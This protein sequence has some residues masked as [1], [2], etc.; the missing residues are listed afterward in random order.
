[1]RG[2]FVVA[3]PEVSSTMRWTKK[4]VRAGAEYVN[5]ILPSHWDATK[6]A[7]FQSRFRPAPVKP[8]LENLRLAVW[9]LKA[10]QD[11]A[12]GEGVSWGFRAR[13][14]VR[15]GQSRG[16]LSAYPETTGYI[17]ET[18]LDYGH[19]YGDTDAVARALRMGDW[20]VRMQL[21][22]GG[23]QGGMYGAEPVSSS[24]FV[25]GQ[26][27]F[28]LLKLYDETQ[29][30]RFLEAAERSG[31][32]L[33]S[34]LDDTGRFVRGHSHFCAAGP[35]AYEARTGW[36]LALLGRTTGERHYSDAARKMAEYAISC[37]QANGWF[38]ENDLDDHSVPLTHTIGYVLEGLWGIGEVLRFPECQDSVLRSLE[39]I[40]RLVE[41]DGFL[42]G[43]WKSDW[44]PAVSYC[45]L[46]GSCQ[47]AIVYLRAYRTHG[48]PNFLATAERLLGFVTATQGTPDRRQPY[49]GGIQGSYPFGGD[50]GQ[51]CLLN[52]ATK[53]FVDALMELFAST[54]RDIG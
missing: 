19:R 24:T 54:G 3:E 12:G 8:A 30:R 16:W 43:R 31:G 13:T 48:R 36:A 33:L 11:A 44:Q 32:F 53:F 23:T 25:T 41:P 42:P 15:S 49:R 5:A 47:I 2:E 17:I 35:K 4:M 52:W 20:E 10:A 29:E 34:C 40:D 1:M 46:T 7:H 26:V 50:Y 27:L 51:F 9:W 6:L 21:P 38:G 22:D 14:V 39:Q 28:G 45:C 18:M 37:Q